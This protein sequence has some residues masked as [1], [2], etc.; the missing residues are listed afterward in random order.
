MR[1]PRQVVSSSNALTSLSMASMDQA[2]SFSPRRI[3]RHR[4]PI[5]DE[6][7]K[8]LFPTGPA[9]VLL[10]SM[11]VALA[12]KMTFPSSDMA[13]QAKPVRVSTSQDQTS[14]M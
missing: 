14:V 12:S 3:A 4:S 6:F 1:P 8:G 7:K 10:A 13:N 11:S 9:T 2:G 5:G